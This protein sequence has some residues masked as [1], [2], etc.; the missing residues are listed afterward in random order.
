MFD[1]RKDSKGFTIN[2]DLTKVRGDICYK[3]RQ[4]R[5]KGTFKH[6]WTRDGNIKIRLHN[7]S[8]KTINT[9]AK[10]DKLIDEL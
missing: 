10:L 8:V 7:D 2:E 4:E 6:V 1:A 5:N 9:L 3:A